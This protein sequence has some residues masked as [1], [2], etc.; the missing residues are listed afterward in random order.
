[1]RRGLSGDDVY[2]WK[3]FLLGYYPYSEIVLDNDTFDDVTYFETKEFQRSVGFTGDDIDGVVGPLTVAK[4]LTLGYDLF[5]D[6]STDETGPSWPSQPADL[7]RMSQEQRSTT[8]GSFHFVPADIPGNPEAIRITDNWQKNIIAVAFPERI[9]NF[10]SALFHRAAAPQFTALLNAWHAAGMWD[11]I[12][13]WGG[14][15]VPRF[16]RGSRSALS[17]HSWGTAFDI[18]VKWNQ[19]GRVPALKGKN[20]SVRELVQL[21]TEHGFFWGGWFK[22]RADGM[23]FEVARLV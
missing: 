14:S 4:A 3:A 22:G 13:T 11:K 19:L 12:L 17:N 8:F 2:A 10:H 15:W 9:E 21:A 7:T 18:N 6:D 1:L 23:H 5:T 20:G 16:V